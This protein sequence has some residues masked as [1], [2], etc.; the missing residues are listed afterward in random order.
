VQKQS[1]LLSESLNLTE[2][3]VI[4][5]TAGEWGEPTCWQCDLIPV[6]WNQS[7]MTR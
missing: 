1:A 2:L 4:C 3:K 6:C 7:K 5:T